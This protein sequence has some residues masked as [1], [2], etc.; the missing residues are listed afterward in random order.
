MRN[1][2]IVTG[3]REDG[4]EDTGDSRFGSSNRAKGW[5]REDRLE[6]DHESGDSKFG[7]SNRANGW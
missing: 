7:S 2:E 4:D 6:E 3:K 5:K 1:L